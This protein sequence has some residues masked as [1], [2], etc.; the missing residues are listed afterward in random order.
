MVTIPWYS[1]AKMDAT[2]AHRA[3]GKETSV[4]LTCVPPLGVVVQ[5][6]LAGEEDPCRALKF[7]SGDR[8]QCQNLLLF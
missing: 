3:W 5:N 1:G 7:G 6:Y 4:L 8:I 2:V